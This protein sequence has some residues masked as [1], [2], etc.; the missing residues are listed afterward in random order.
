[1]SGAM[2]YELKYRLPIRVI[3]EIRDQIVPHVRFDPHCACRAGHHYTVRSIYF[4]SDDLCFYHEKHDGV[5]VRRKLRVRTYGEFAADSVAF[6][7][8]KRKFG[9]RGCKERLCLPLDLVATALNG[10]ARRDDLVQ[11]RR[12]RIVLAKVGHLVALKKLRPVVLVTYE[13]EAHIGRRD[14]RLRVTFDR[15]IRSLIDPTLEQIHRERE[16]QQFE[17]RNFV[18]EL[19]YDDRMPGWMA[20]LIR[21]LNLVANPYSKYCHGIDAWSER[22]G[23]PHP[24]P[25]QTEKIAVAPRPARCPDHRLPEKS[26]VS[27]G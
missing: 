4:D 18:L 19:K 14:E 24:V 8:I 13:R 7:E 27:H 12:D 22:N 15:N 11:R 5:R 1:M 25:E 6:I 26:R 20:R 3:A 16:L 17:D 23:K 2:R 9:R 10:G 21:Q